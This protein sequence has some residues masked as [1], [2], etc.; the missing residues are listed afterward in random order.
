[1]KK[2]IIFAVTNDLV[3]DRRMIRICETLSTRYE[4]VLIG[5]R[6]GNQRLLKEQKFKQIRLR[7]LF[8]KGK[9]FYIEY[10]LRL[11]FYLLFHKSNAICAIDLDTILPSFLVSK[12]KNWTC[13]FDAH[14]Y[15]T[16]VPEVVNRP[17]TKSIWEAVARFTVPNIKYCYT[18]SPSLAKIF[19]GIY[20]TPF[21]VIRNVPISIEKQE[22]PKGFSDV[23]QP[24]LGHSST[25]A[26]PY[27]DQSRPFIILYQGALNKGRGVGEAIQS[28][29]LT[30]NAELWL[31]GEGDES[32]SLRLLTKQLNLESKVKFLGMVSPEKLRV[33]TQKA[34]IGLNLL[35]NLGLSYFYSLANKFF[36]YI[37]EGIP[38]ITMQYPEYQEINDKHE[39]ALL[40]NNLEVKTIANAIN[41]LRSNAERYNSL[42]R[43]ALEASKIYNWKIEGERLLGFYEATGL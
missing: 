9:F 1:M 34:D 37:Q 7:L 5:R 30:E 6:Q 32:E 20:K 41:E 13:V 11:F 29:T 2:K 35:E 12:I 42:S 23:P 14:E 10:N 38:Q 4:I 15:F 18:V 25:I 31:A 43:N 22:P 17:L 33:F 36:D 40:I 3:N 24:T 28:M 27:L 19:E 21:E 16:E 39:V 26:E 8:Q